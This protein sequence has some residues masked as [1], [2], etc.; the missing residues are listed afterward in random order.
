MPRL[1]N[2]A[3]G[4]VVSVSDETAARLGADYVPVEHESRPASAV[5]SEKPAPVK[6]SPRKPRK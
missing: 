6:R 5:D 2:S 4:V 3:S 1:R